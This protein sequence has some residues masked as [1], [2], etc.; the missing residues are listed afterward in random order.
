MKVLLI[1]GSAI[2][3]GNTFVALTEIAK[4]LQT[5]GI[6][7]EIIQLGNKPVRG[8][9]ACGTCSSKG[10]GRC[11]FDDDICNKIIEKAQMLL[12]LVHPFITANL[13]VLCLPLYNECYMPAE[14][15]SNL[16]L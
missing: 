3:K 14:K 5:E 2:K 12:F 16:N 15:P 4:T 7:S 6:D 10:N 8:C 13:M 9:I 11:T 1:N